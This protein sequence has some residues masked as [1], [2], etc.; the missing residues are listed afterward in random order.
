MGGKVYL[1]T[2]R[3]DVKLEG[4]TFKP[5]DFDH[6][7]GMDFL[8]PHGK[9]WNRPPVVGV[10]VMRH[11][12][13]PS[14]LL[15]LLCFGVGCVILRFAAGE[16]LP[17]S[18]C[19]FLSDKRIH[20]VAFG[21]PEKRELFPF[22]ELGLKTRKVDVGYLAAKAL[23]QPKCRKWDLPMLARR[24]LGIKKMV[25]LTDASSPERHAIKSA[26]C[27]LFITSIIGLGLLNVDGSKL[28]A[29][30]PSRRS[31][32]LKNLNSLG[33]FAEGL[34]KNRK[35]MGKLERVGSVLV[36]IGDSDDLSSQDLCG[37]DDDT[38]SSEKMPLK[39]I[40]K[41]PSSTGL[42]SCKSVRYEEESS[43]SAML[44]RANSKGHNVSFNC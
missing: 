31:S 44:K 23:N 19:R 9:I 1:R 20:F 7:C 6:L 36:R 3:F 5:K 28:D 2:D 13:D 26:I 42:R 25:G 38:R 18:I 17:S 4:I 29:A 34:F 21:I 39:G 15:V 27:R 12:R 37:G 30:S 40:L 22:K 35:K 41:C 11:P 10:D 24:I 33:S 14:I 8:F 43:A 32:L 16:P